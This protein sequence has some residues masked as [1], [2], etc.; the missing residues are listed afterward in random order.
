MVRRREL[1]KGGAASVI[2]ATAG[3]T[4]LES[5]PLEAIEL[6]IVD[7]RTPNVGFT[8]ATLPLVLEFRN[9][10]DSSI[11]DV[12][13]SFDV[14][15]NSSMV[16]NAGTSVGTL[17]AGERTRSRLEVIVDYDAVGDAVLNALEQGRFDILL[18]GTIEA[19]GA[20]PFAEASRD[21]RLE[22]QTT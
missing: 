21:V 18:D 22:A 8:S 1:I 14:Y 15:V 16:A 13:T 9:G 7:I 2:M 19:A 11:S 20:L 5:P 10:S 17:G 6:G 4:E 3:C 12:S